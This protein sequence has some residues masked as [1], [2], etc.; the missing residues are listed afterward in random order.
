MRGQRQRRPWLSSRHSVMRGIRISTSS[1]GE[2]RS[3]PSL[4][5]RRKAHSTSMLRRHIGPQRGRHYSDCAATVCSPV[6]RVAGCCLAASGPNGAAQ[7]PGSGVFYN[8]NVPLVEVVS[9]QGEAFMRFRIKP[10][11]AN[12]PEPP[13]TRGR[14]AGEVQHISFIARLPEQANLQ[15]VGAILA[16]DEHAPGRSVASSWGWNIMHSSLT[17]STNQESQKSEAL[18]CNGACANS[19]VSSVYRKRC[20]DQPKWRELDVC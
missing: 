8:K 2:R 19:E 9:D 15:D 6:D 17:G 7:W 18:W 12:G 10:S 13:S 14:E 11:S 3:A 20:A 4:E 16:E 5:V 1:S